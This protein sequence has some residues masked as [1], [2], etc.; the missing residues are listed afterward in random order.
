MSF[1][2]RDPKEGRVEAL[3]LRQEGAMQYCWQSAWFSV[4]PALWNPRHGIPTNVQHA[5]TG[6]VQGTNATCP[7]RVRRAACCENMG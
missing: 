5:K 6:L 2:W 7:P 1:S 3:G 4:P